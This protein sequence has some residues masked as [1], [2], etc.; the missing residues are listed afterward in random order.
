MQGTKGKE[1]KTCWENATPRIAGRKETLPS[2]SPWKQLKVHS[3][4]S[5]KKQE[6]K[7]F[8]SF[9]VPSCHITSFTSTRVTAQKNRM[10]YCSVAHI[11]AGQ[12]D[13]AGHQGGKSSPWG[14]FPST[15]AGGGIKGSQLFSCYNSK[16]PATRT[17]GSINTLTMTVAI[18]KKSG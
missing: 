17:K 5:P 11:R 14:L 4:D 7:C 10:L 9:V 8:L 16:A 18:S 6:N 13:P 2:P 12:D 1:P 15:Q 3:Q